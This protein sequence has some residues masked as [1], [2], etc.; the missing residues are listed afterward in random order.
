MKKSFQIGEQRRVRFLIGQRF[1]ALLAFFHNEFIQRGIDG[2][3]I[4]A[5]KT[6]QTEAVQWFSGRSHHAFHIE[7]TQT[8]NAQILADL[9]H[10]HLIGD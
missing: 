4:I 10:R 2:Q 7:V 8:V 5:G 3:G 9:F 1:G 6:S